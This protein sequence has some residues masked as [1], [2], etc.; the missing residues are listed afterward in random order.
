MSILDGL[1]AYLTSSLVKT[2]SQSLDE[3]QA[4][5]STALHSLLPT[6]LGGLVQK[7]ESD[8]GLD[9]VFGVIE[10]NGNPAWLD[11]L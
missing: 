2:V 5:V 10:T 3:S 6:I 7:A 4:G 1:Q 8:R 11:D 9:Q